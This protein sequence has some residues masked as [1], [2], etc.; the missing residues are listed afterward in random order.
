MNVCSTSI[1]GFMCNTFEA[2][3]QFHGNLPNNSVSFCGM[4]SS[5]TRK[6]TYCVQL[7]NHHLF[8]GLA[9]LL[10]QEVPKRKT[11]SVRA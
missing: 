2:C 4:P 11:C 10:V 5:I 8:P 3:M 6:I 7:C 1:S 9:I